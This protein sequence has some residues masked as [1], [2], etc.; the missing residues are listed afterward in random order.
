M[1]HALQLMNVLIL[2]A[3]AHPPVFCS[4]YNPGQAMRG[5]EVSKLG[6]NPILD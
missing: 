6:T 1:F 2:I 3:G 5:A 4:M